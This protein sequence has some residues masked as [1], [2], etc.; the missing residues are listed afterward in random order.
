LVPVILIHE[1]EFA[2]PQTSAAAVPRQEL[3]RSDGSEPRA[4]VLLKG[5]MPRHKENAQPPPF[6]SR[7]FTSLKIPLYAAHREAI[8]KFDASF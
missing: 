2:A 6:E 8:G 7:L 5:D 4:G 1:A 3:P